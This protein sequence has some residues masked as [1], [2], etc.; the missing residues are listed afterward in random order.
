[1][2]KR[3]LRLSVLAMSMMA[4]QSYSYAATE[5]T[6]STMPLRLQNNATIEEVSVT[7]PFIEEEEESQNLITNQQDYPGP[8]PNVMLVLDDSGSMSDSVD[9]ERDPPPNQSRMAILKEVMKEVIQEH[10]QKAN[11]GITWFNNAFSVQPDLPLGTPANQ[12]NNNIQNSKEGGPTPTIETVLKAAR[13]LQKGIEYRCQKSYLILMSDGDANTSTQSKNNDFFPNK[14]GLY[15]QSMLGYWLRVNRILNSENNRSDVWHRALG[16]E[17]GYKSPS[18]ELGQFMN[19]LLSQQNYGGKNTYTRDFLYYPY[20]GTVV[21]NEL[22]NIPEGKGFKQNVNRFGQ[23]FYTYFDKNNQ[24][25]SVNDPNR[26]YLNLSCAKLLDLPSEFVGRENSTYGHG[27]YCDAFNSNTIDLVYNNPNNYNTAFQGTLTGSGLVYNRMYAPN[28]A[29]YM[30]KYLTDALKNQDLKK[31]GDSHPG[32]LNARTD[33][34][35]KS[36][37][38]P[39]SLNTSKQNIQTFSI[40][41]GSSVSPPGQEFLAGVGDGYF[42]SA[43]DRQNLMSAFKRIFDTIQAQNPTPTPGQ[44][45]TSVFPS[46]IGATISPPKDGQGNASVSRLDSFAS[47]APSTTGAG[48]A[49]S[50]PNMAASVFLPGGLTSSE[51]RFFDLDESANVK[52]DPTTNQPKYRTANFAERKTLIH[53]GSDVTWAD[54]PSGVFSNRMFNLAVDAQGRTDEWRNALLPWITRLK[55]DSFIANMNYGTPYRTRNTMERNMGDVLDTPVVAQG[56]RDVLDG[57]RQRFLVTAA[58]DGLVYLFKSDP[59]KDAEHPYS[60]KLNYMPAS[61]PKHNGTLAGDLYKIANKDYVSVNNPHIYMINGGLSVRATSKSEARPY[62]Q[63][64]MVGNMGQG[65][66]GVYGLNIGGKDFHSGQNIALDNNNSSAWLTEV[67][68]FEANANQAGLS[69]LGYTV[70]SPQ[71]GRIRTQLGTDGNVGVS[72]DFK[73]NIR[74]GAFVGSGYAYPD[75][76]SQETALYIFDALGKDIGTNPSDKSTSGTGQLLLGGKIIVTN[77]VGG[78]SSP[79]L[80]DV[81]FDGVVD[82]AFAGD[83]GGNMYRFDLRDPQMTS[84]RRVQ[85][86][87]TGLPSQPITVAP[88]ISRQPN[89]RYVVAW[90]TGTDIYQEDL[91]SKAQQAIYGIYQRFDVNKNL[92]PLDKNEDTPETEFPVSSDKLLSQEFSTTEINGQNFR[93]VTDNKIFDETSPSKLLYSGWK[94]NLGEVDG[95][96]VTADGATL[97]GTFVLSSH[98]YQRQATKAPNTTPWHKDTWAQNGWE[99]VGD[100]IKSVKKEGVWSSWQKVGNPTS[101]TNT[102]TG[103]EADICLGTTSTLTETQTRKRTNEWTETKKYQR[104]HE[105]EIKSSGWILQLDMVNGGALNTGAGDTELEVGVDFIRAFTRG[106]GNNKLAGSDSPTFLAGQYVSDGQPNSAILSAEYTGSSRNNEGQMNT[107]GFDD[108]FDGS[109]SNIPDIDKRCLSTDKNFN[110]SQNTATGLDANSKQ[111]FG[112]LCGGNPGIKRISWREIF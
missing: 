58:N 41:F 44:P 76:D 61:M 111:I 109:G 93:N 96:R 98:M 34:A 99:E 37:D 100:V 67:P 48:S 57:G 32:N 86:I 72:K 15:S 92:E 16:Q 88:T 43:A 81:N 87:Y 50:I 64:F 89:G 70:G 28:H 14:T 60:L 11:W 17:Y 102:N 18:S 90:G 107:S 42:Y 52:L 56:P 95:E 84:E 7:Q 31:E 21:S 27:K 3:K 79:A 10:G 51:L 46:P 106:E 38:D 80:L 12:V 30:L 2:K 105:G 85:R 77:G 94:V 45:V 82:Y 91:E 24:E 9:G 53:S 78:L 49:Q 68:L 108:E 40:S 22:P 4:I 73:E 83:Y 62:E 63:I 74:Y 23:I 97:L 110:I 54:N 20:T 112:K 1:M 71:L 55:D 36:W 26:S 75:K 5:P 59:N 13:L 35:G 47:T 25:V 65:G 19:K 39:S 103:V 8:K 104:V 29:K 33:K 69:G 66:R 6:F 101:T